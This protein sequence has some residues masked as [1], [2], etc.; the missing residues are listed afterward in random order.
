LILLALLAGMASGNRYD[1]ASV[2]AGWALGFYKTNISPLQ[3]QRVCN[4]EPTCSRFSKQAIERYGL[5]VGILMTADRLERCN[6]YAQF[7]LG[8]YYQGITDG[9]MDDP[10]EEHGPSRGSGVGGRGSGEGAADFGF[11]IA[12][13]P[14]PVGPTT[15]RA[16]RL[17]NAECRI[18]TARFAASEE[19][20][21]ADY[22]FGK[23]D[24]QRAIGEY[25]RSVFTDTA[26]KGRTYARLMIAESRY[27]QGDYAAAN[28]SFRDA[29]GPGDF[30]LAY[31]GMARSLL[32]LGRTHAAR[33]YALV[34]RDSALLKAATAVVAESY[35]QRYDFAAG[36]KVMGRFQGDSVLGGLGSMDGRG[37]A[38]RSPVLSAVLSTAIPGLGQTYAGRLGDGLFSLVVVGTAAAASWYYWNKPE[39]DPGRVKFGICAGL[40]AVFHLGNIYGAAIAGRDYNRRQQR[41][42]Q[43]RVDAVLSRISLQP[44]YWQYLNR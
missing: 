5:G 36:A 37:I 21:F 2:A 3:G 9:R 12:D 19:L 26:S 11:Q 40:G 31:L 6:P 42:Y 23:G 35:F 4:F 16:G 28:S 41:D 25:E 1:A 15:G 18:D 20:R 43:A 8:S 17:Q 38:R 29:I 7:Y 13:Y 33:H 30:E 14:E 10:V 32:K 39:Q 24:Y 22:L 44:D 34:I 27:R